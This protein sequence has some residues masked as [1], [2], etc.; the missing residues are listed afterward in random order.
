MKQDKEQGGESMEYTGEGCN[1]C[2]GWLIMS[3]NF[4]H[5]KSIA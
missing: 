1:D 2:N 5:N 3:C 4:T